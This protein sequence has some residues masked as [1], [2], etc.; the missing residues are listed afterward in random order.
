MQ[1]KRTPW[2]MIQLWGQPRLLGKASP[3]ERTHF[4]RDKTHYFIFAAHLQGWKKTF[5]DW[6]VTPKLFTLRTQC[7]S[8]IEWTSFWSLAIIFCLTL[9]RN[10]SGIVIQMCGFL[11]NI[12]IYI[13]SMCTW[14]INAIGFLSSDVGIRPQ[15]SLSISSQDSTRKCGYWLWGLKS[16]MWSE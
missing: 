16:G 12:Y 14:Y 2:I 5:R 15:N 11:K 1:W 7:S 6:M 13:Y 3:I 4:R 9:V 10:N 8:Y